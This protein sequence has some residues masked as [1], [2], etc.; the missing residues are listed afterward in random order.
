[1]SHNI[2]KILIATKMNKNI[3]LGL[4]AVLVI[5]TTGLFFPRGN[6]VVQQVLGSVS[7]LDG[8]DNP[9]I[10]IAGKREWKQ[11]I[12]LNATSSMVLSLL[13]PLA[14]TSTVT[15]L[16][17]ESTNVG[18]AQANNLF[19]GTTTQASRY[20]TTS[21]TAWNSG[22]A[23]GTGEWSYKFVGNTATT[24]SDAEALGAPTN[25]LEGMNANSSSNY[26]LGATEVLYAKF[27]TS[28]AGT[29]VTYDVGACNV[30]IEKI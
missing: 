23:M 24:T 2:T 27:G 9:S 13:N 28:T 20:A 1:M 26:I 29:F 15:Y 21:V 22:F 6:T 14:A 11:Q 30:T 8:V 25:V 3:V 17:C 10:S 5:A 19:F 4:V 16:S 12:P 18:V 7:T